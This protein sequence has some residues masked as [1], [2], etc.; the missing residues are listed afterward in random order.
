MPATNMCS[1]FGSK[2]SSFFFYQM[3]HIQL[4]LVFSLYF[5]AF[6]QKYTKKISIKVKKCFSDQSEPYTAKLIFSGVLK[7]FCRS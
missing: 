3:S 4:K 7:H 5:V 2:W 1:I 6:M